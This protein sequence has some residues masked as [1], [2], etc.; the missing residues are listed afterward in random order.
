M[1]RLRSILGQLRAPRRLSQ[2][3]EQIAAR[4]LRRRGYRI[5]GK[6]VRNRFGE[7][8]LVAQAPDRR[9]IVVVEVKSGSSGPIPPE[10]HVNRPKQR[11]LAA[12]AAQLAR[13]HGLENRPFRFDVIGVDL[14]EGAEPV[15]RHHEGS[16]PSPI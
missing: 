1:S 9:T 12:L 2:R 8:D 13:R 16:F 11:K 15:V 10:V 5:L 7:I 14:P 6:N 4:F 3:G